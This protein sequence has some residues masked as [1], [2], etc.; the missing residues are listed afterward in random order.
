MGEDQ[1]GGEEEKNC[2]AE[3]EEEKKSKA[4]GEEKG[5]KKTLRYRPNCRCFSRRQYT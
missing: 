5:I 2:I 1:I 4:E 3:G